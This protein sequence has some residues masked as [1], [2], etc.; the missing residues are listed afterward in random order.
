MQ[1]NA[2]QNLDT[3]VP[4]STPILFPSSSSTAGAASS[5]TMPQNMNVDRSDGVK[6]DNGDDSS[7]SKK[8]QRKEEAP[9]AQTDAEQSKAIPKSLVTS[10]PP[11]TI[12]KRI[13]KKNEIPRL[14]KKEKLLNALNALID[15]EKSKAIPTSLDIP[16]IVDT[17]KIVKVSKEVFKNIC[18]SMKK[19]NRKP[20]D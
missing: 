20:L 11:Q 4:Q 19:I 12:K 8:T 2:A 6:R 10:K 18:N 16:K 14:T 15:A 5:S 7:K 13:S 17:P 1:Q 3:E 9:I